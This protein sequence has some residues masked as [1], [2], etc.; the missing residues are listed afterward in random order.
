MSISMSPEYML[1]YLPLV[2][3]VSLVLAATRHERPDLIFNQAWRTGLWITAFM[4]GI[5]LILYL[6]SLWI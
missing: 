6:S 1:F 3:A 5:S 2:V 4:L